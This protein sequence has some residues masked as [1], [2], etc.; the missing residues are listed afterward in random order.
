MKKMTLIVMLL[1]CSSAFASLK[2]E[3]Q[4]FKF[5][6]NFK[7][8]IYQYSQKSESFERA[9]EL[10]AKACYKHYKAGQKLSEDKGLDI[11]DVCANPRSI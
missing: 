4:E 11:I 6:F 5:K 8:D 1:A 3:A 2:K 10:A 7:G 9:Y